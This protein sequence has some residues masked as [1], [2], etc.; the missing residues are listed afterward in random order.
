MYEVQF[1]SF[2]LLNK[3]FIK[4]KKS[5]VRLTVYPA[6]FKIKI[7]L[8]CLHSRMVPGEYLQ[9]FTYPYFF[10]ETKL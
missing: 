7:F 8:P 2:F 9:Y 6:S 1:P 3:V 10:L 4:Q 5:F